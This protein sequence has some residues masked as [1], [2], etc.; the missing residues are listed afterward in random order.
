MTDPENFPFQRA[1]AA[2]YHDA[3]LFHFCPEGSVVEPGRIF[4]HRQCR[5]HRVRRS[6]QRK[7]QSCQSGPETAGDLF[8][9]GIAGLQSFIQNHPHRLGQSLNQIH[10]RRGKIQGRIVHDRQ[11]VL[12]VH[13]ISRY[14][15][16]LLPT[17]QRLVVERYDRQ[18][19]RRAKGFL[20]RRDYHVNAIVFHGFGDAGAG[21]DPVQ[22]K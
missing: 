15:T 13:I 6:N 2:G 12:P 8:M 1:D 5:R 7:P 22:D 10:R 17:G 19:R 14:R 21:A 4:D 18:A 16:E 11:P 3:V 9:S 20:A